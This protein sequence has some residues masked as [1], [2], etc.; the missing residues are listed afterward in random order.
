[1]SVQPY[2]VHEAEIALFHA[3]GDG[4]PV[5][6]P[7]ARHLRPVVEDEFKVGLKIS[8]V[9]ASEALAGEFGEWRRH[10]PQAVGNADWLVET[11]TLLGAPVDDGG[12]QLGSFL[13]P[14]M[15]VILVVRFLCADT[16]RWRL[17]QFHD[18][19]V[20][21]AEA[22]DENQWMRQKVQFSAGH[23]EEFK[24][25]T[26]PPLVPKLRGVIEWRHLGRRVRCWE[27]DPVGDTLMEDD[28]NV[29]TVGEETVRYVSI[30]PGVDGVGL[31][32]MAAKTVDATS[33][34]LPA[35]GIGWIDAITLSV[36][37]SSGLILSPGWRLETEG[38]AEP[39]LLPPSGR[40]WEHPRVVFRFL[41]RTYATLQ[42]GV[43][44]MPSFTEGLPDLPLDTP[45]RIGRLALYPEG[46]WLV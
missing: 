42:A 15:P 1:M 10:R 44:A 35:T 12:V 45:I 30:E 18:C 6:G 27:Y 21:P 29:Q 7:F 40:H 37:W 24:S 39:I 32:Y 25:G 34:G 5:G 38:C 31:S 20:L 26:L 46:G 28:E 9:D 16:G 11:G 17:L 41:G 19:V 22:G 3:W 4:M 8:Q 43:F 2:T 13:I 23:L 36:N 33:G 14:G